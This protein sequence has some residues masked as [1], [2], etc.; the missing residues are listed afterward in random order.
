MST[1]ADGRTLPDSVTAS[2]DRDGRLVYAIDRGS[3]HGFVL[4]LSFFGVAVA[5][6][7]ATVQAIRSRAV[8]DI[9]IALSFT[10]LALVLWAAFLGADRTRVRVVAGVLLLHRSDT[11]QRF[12]LRDPQVSLEETGDRRSKK[13]R[14]HLTGPGGRTATLTRSQVDPDGLAAVVAQYRL[15]SAPEGL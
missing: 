2:R 15:G 12:D 8:D 9:G 6:A 5:A 4:V 11:E 14:T 10:S 1:T 13:W 7:L 3:R